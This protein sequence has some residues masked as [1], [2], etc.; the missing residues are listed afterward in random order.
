MRTWRL[1]RVI[2][3]VL[4]CVSSP[5]LA[6]QVAIIANLQNTQPELDLKQIRDLYLKRTKAWASGERVILIDLPPELPESRLFRTKVL[7]KSP[8]ELERHWIGLKRLGENRP[9]VLPDNQMVIMMVS[10]FPQA[11][12]Y[13]NA[14]SLKAAAK[15]PVRILARLEE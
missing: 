6:L 11:I 3:L 8:A 9:Q 4:F 12:G 5:C 1:P 14:E 2:V 15:L 13:V 10:N 7:E